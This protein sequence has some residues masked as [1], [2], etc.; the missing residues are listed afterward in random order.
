M[1][2]TTPS[3]SSPRSPA[4]PGSRSAFTT[5]KSSSRNCS[6]SVGALANGSSQEASASRP[7]PAQRS[8][9]ASSILSG[10]ATAGRNGSSRIAST[11]GRGSKSSASTTIPA[12]VEWAKL[13]E[14]GAAILRLAGIPYS[15]GWQ[16]REIGRG[17]GISGP[18]VLGLLDELADEIAG[19][20]SLS[21]LRPRRGATLTFLFR[22]ETADGK[23][24]EP[25]TLRSAVPNWRPGDT[26][27]LGADRTLRV[28]EVRSEGDDEQPVLVVADLAE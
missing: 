20:D 4:V 24:A 14:R 22:L 13:S 6:S 16:P 26:I 17:L 21:P 15:E 19:L 8:G 3:I 12:N 7:T 2:S 23:P 9:S 27:P 11:N 25:P 10:S 28:V 1:T 5:A 18:S